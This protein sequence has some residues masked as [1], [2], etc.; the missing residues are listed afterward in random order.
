MRSR[1]LWLLSAICVVPAAGAFWLHRHSTRFDD[2]IA[3]A[4]A[5]HAVDYYVVKAIIFE[6][7]WFRP[8][9]RGTAGEYGLM[10]ITLAAAADFTNTKSF[11]ALYRP[12][13]LEPE[14]NIEIGCW[15]LRQSLNRYKDTPQPML[16]ALLRYNAGEVRAD[17]WAKLALGSPVPPHRTPENHYLSLVDFPKTREYARRVLERARSRNFWL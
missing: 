1:S 6:E 7:S 15:Y 13:L 17:H 9:V 12:R 8:D 16:F 4:S 5:R 3:Q 2:V 10:Q 11:P 14:L